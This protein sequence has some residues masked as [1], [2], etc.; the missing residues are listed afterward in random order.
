MSEFMNRN[1]HIVFFAIAS[2]LVLLYP[3]FIGDTFFSY[4]SMAHYIRMK[5]T[6]EQFLHFDMPPLFDYY[7]NSWYGYSWNMFYPPLSSYVMW[8]IKPLTFYSITDVSQFKASI[9]MIILISFLSMY[10]S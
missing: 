5:D 4:D 1:R 9:G 6:N 3:C 7:S 8:A 2:L 10:I